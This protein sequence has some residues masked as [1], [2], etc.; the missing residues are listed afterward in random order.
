MPEGGIDSLTGALS[1]GRIAIRPL[2]TLAERIRPHVTLPPSQVEAILEALSALYSVRVENEQSVD[3]FIRDVSMAMRRGGVEGESISDGEASKLE[4]RLTRLLSIES[5][6]ISSKASDLQ[7]A[8]ERVFD[9]AR[10]FTDIRPVFGGEGVGDVRG[11]V[12]INQLRISC[13]EGPGVKDFFFALDQD[14]L[15]ALKKVLEGAEG[16]TKT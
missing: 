4:E 3:A 15:V 14:D 7:F 12:M 11:A 13:V 16:K 8:H 6:T 2:S 1:S 5:F 10:I 9:S